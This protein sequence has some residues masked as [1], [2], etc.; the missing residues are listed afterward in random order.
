MHSDHPERPDLH[1]YN[2]YLLQLKCSA[3]QDKV[4][5]DADGAHNGDADPHPGGQA[6]GHADAHAGGHTD[7]SADEHADGHADRHA[8]GRADAE[9]SK[10][11]VDDANAHVC[12]ERTG[13]EQVQDRWV[14]SD[15]VHKAAVTK[16]NKSKAVRLYNEL[17]L[18][19][20]LNENS[21]CCCKRCRSQLSLFWH[22]VKEIMQNI[23][24]DRWGVAH[25]DMSE[26]C[27]PHLL[28]GYVICDTCFT[29]NEWDKATNSMIR[30]TFSGVR[31]ASLVVVQLNLQPG[32]IDQTRHAGEQLAAIMAEHQPLQLVALQDNSTIKNNAVLSPEGTMAIG[33]A[34]AIGSAFAALHVA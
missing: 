9:A 25:I 3:V 19:C 11:V 29:D 15:N 12:G 22:F 23:I 31:P 32:D 16:H 18:H 5:D 14:I 28:Q 4:N 21:I 1:I 13:Q 17:N 33:M 2:E 6:D 10:A 24:Q 27:M 26:A 20:K 7:G 30:L 8:D 34:A